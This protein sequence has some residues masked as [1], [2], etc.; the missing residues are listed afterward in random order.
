MKRILPVYFILLHSFVCGQVID[1][2]SD[3]DFTN[4]PTWSGDVDFFK[5]ENDTLRSD[6]SAASGI[7]F[8][9]TP[10]TAISSAT[11]EFLVKLDFLP[12]TSNQVKIYLVSDQA[13]LEGDLNGYFIEIGQSGDDAIK[14]RRQSGTNSTTLFTG[15]TIFTG[16]ILVRI[17]VTRDNAGNWEV[18]SDQMGASNFS[19]EGDSFLDP[20]LGTS[21]YFG[22]VCKHTSTR[23]NL[24]FFD[25]FSIAIEADIDAPKI[26]A[27]Q[28][29]S[30]T[31]L[32]IQFDESL[33]QATAE[34]ASNYFVNAGIGQPT[35][36][37]LDIVDNSLVHLTFSKSFTNNSNYDITVKNVE[38]VNGNAIANKV[39]TFNFLIPEIAVNHDIVI[40]EIM[41]DPTPEVGLPVSE[42]VEIY[43]RSS[44]YIDLAN[45]TLSDKRITSTSQIIEPNEYLILCECGDVSLFQSFGD[46]IGLTS[47]NALTN[48]GEK[49][50]LKDVGNSL[51]IDELTYTK[52]WYKDE[53]KEEGGW[54]LELIN[55]DHQC[56]G[57]DN[58]HASESTIGG[59]PGALNTVFDNTLDITGPIL[60]SAIALSADSLQLAFDERLDTTTFGLATFTFDPIVAVDAIALQDDLQTVIITFMEELQ[61]TTTYNVSVAS[62]RDCSGNVIATDQSSNFFI[63]SIAANKDIVINEIMADPTPEVGLPTSEWVEIYNRSDQFFDLKDYTLNDKKIISTSYVLSPNEYVLLLPE[64][65]ASLFSSFGNVIGLGSW[66]VL[67]NS[68]EEITLKNSLGNIIDV[69][70]YDDS[71][72][73]SIV[74]GEGGW[75]LELIDPENK[76]GEETNWSASIDANGGSP[77][78]VNSINSS[79]P[80]LTG[81]SLLS[82]IAITQDSLILKFDERLDT[83]TFQSVKYDFE[84]ILSVDHTALS[85][86]GREITIVLSSRIE[87]SIA[88]QI[89]VTFLRDCNGNLIGTENTKLFTLPQEASSGDLLINELLYNPITSGTDFVEIYNRSSKYINLNGWSIANGSKDSPDNHQIITTDNL[90]ILPQQYLAFTEQAMIL[91]SDYPKGVLENIVEVMSLPPFPN[92]D[93]GVVLLDRN[94]IVFDYFP[95]EESMQ[96][97]LLDDTKGVSLERISVDYPTE[98]RDNWH[99]AAKNVGYATPGYRNSQALGTIVNVN[100]QVVISP[101]VF[102]P[103]QS[104]QNDFSTINYSF[105]QPGFVASVSIVDVGGRVIKRIAQ[106]ELLPTQGFFQWNGTR[107]NGSKARSGVYIVHFEVFNLS[108][109]LQIIQ[110]RVVISSKL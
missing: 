104:G 7:L 25:D 73:N 21:S 14:F 3:G 23:K 15:R 102:L 99:S 65:Q 18:Y 60:L 89:V 48:G 27:V 72:Y 76:C 81:P 103:N 86:N 105:D 20:T 90:L 41:A 34:T 83:T 66:D 49:V 108:G 79:K 9:S 31:Q 54:S 5:I 19:S 1:D 106:N 22:L 80:D 50:T 92:D 46:V 57:E 94:N 35:L 100:D 82:I 95:Y 97:V 13:N 78:H 33:N 61:T 93:Q 12:S 37:V 56:S 107:E 52:S 17:K 59:T 29:I 67:I 101:E 64:D 8:L 91:A 77:G 98:D 63:S 62:V 55:P 2:F 11:W 39:E 4:N 42:Y 84:P 69:I 30:N 71:W 53:E 43:N 32:D 45:Y 70:V 38:D 74:K 6:G 51:V 75:S 85:D 28:V 87:A 40:N 24:F 16:N 44:K 10:S 110:K 88:Y 58:W 26:N 47:W 96:H 109:H 68:G 36:A